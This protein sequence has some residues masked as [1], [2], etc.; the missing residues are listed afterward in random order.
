MCIT[1]RNNLSTIERSLDSI[2]SQVTDRHEVI[3]VDGMSTDGSLELLKRYESEGKIRLIVKKSSRGRGRQLAFEYSTG[4][5]ILA[6][7]D[8][9]EIYPSRML[10]DLAALEPLAKE[11]MV[12]VNDRTVRS[13]SHGFTLCARDIIT[14]LGGWM[15]LNYYEDYELWRRAATQGKY[16]WTV[17]PINI[18]KVAHPERKTMFGRQKHR[19]TGYVNKLR[20]GIPVFG[21]GEKPTASQEVVYS[22]A[23]SVSLFKRSYRD[24]A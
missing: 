17:L 23:K 9:D 5:F 8:L 4:N 21:D 24:P 7:V 1:H 2:L 15:D 13:G 12:M 18:V 11:K 19:Y 14:S 16:V 6:N 20:V 22:I 3:V 10:E